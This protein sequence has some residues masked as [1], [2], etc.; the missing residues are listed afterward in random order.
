MT[1]TGRCFKRLEKRHSI[2]LNHTKKRLF[3]LYISINPDY[4]KRKVPV[5]VNSVE[6]A[7]L[8]TAFS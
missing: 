3:F 7:L 6:H 4:M 1:G 2:T 8:G 5:W